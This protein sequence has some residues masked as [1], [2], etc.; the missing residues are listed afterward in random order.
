[1]LSD[2]NNLKTAIGIGLDDLTQ[3]GKLGQLLVAAD[4]A[5]K[6][7][8]HRD[9][10]TAVY[11]E[12][13]FKGGGPDL[14]LLQ[15]PLRPV[16]L[17]GTLA[18]GS[19]QVTNLIGGGPYSPA[20]LTI[21]QSVAVTGAAAANLRTGLPPFTALTAYDSTTLTATLS[22]N[23]TV[24][25]TVPLIFGLD[26]YIDFGGNYGFG[27]NAF[28][29]GPNN[30]SRLYAGLDYAPEIDAPDGSCQSGLLFLIGQSGYGGGLW[31]LAPFGWGMGGYGPYGGPLTQA[32]PPEWPT[33]P[34]SIRVDYTAGLGVGAVA[35]SGTLPSSTTIPTDLT[36]AVTAVATWMWRNADTGLLTIQSES[37]QGYQ[38]SLVGSATAGL[39]KAT[40]LGSTRDILSRYV[41]VVI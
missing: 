10:E 40:E 12:Y 14:P 20:Q 27:L 24:S 19:N 8:C 15:R 18:A 41:E 35:P 34:G 36:A 23:A 13:P 33:F 6:N 30:S 37:F 38:G 39:Q 7:Y 17:T 32:L 3:D 22:N 4:A 2:L 21:G 9:F 31:S 5:V 29:N 26:V 25:G 28:Q 16:L 11:T 1:M